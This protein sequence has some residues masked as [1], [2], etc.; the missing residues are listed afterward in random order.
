MI[1]RRIAAGFAPAILVTL[2][3]ALARCD[4]PLGAGVEQFEQNVRPLLAAVC[5]K[6]HGQEKQEA[7]LRLDSAAG[8]EAGGDSGPAVV[9]GDPDESRM[10]RAIRY[11]GD[12]K[13]PPDG[14]LSAAE[15]AVLTAWV[16]DGARWP[17]YAEK[18]EATANR[19]K[20]ALAKPP[21]S[22]EPDRPGVDPA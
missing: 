8:V 15:I 14:K 21:A 13:M 16:K 9:P 19:W 10:V 11:A 6:C 5:W 7:S 12:R 22:G 20:A 3:S 2:A 1:A 18:L 4:E 17:K